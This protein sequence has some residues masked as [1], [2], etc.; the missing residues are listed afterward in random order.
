MQ[1]WQQDGQ[2]RGAGA[3]RLLVHGFTTEY[4]IDPETGAT[5]EVDFVE[6]SPAGQEAFIRLRKPMRDVLEIEPLDPNAPLTILAHQRKAVIEEAY[7][8]WKRGGEVPVTGTPLGAWP[9][10][11]AKQAEIIRHAGIASVEDLAGATE[12]Q[13]SR[14]RLPNNYDLR[15]M[16]RRFLAAKPQ[17]QEAG[18]LAKL[19]AEN[20]RLRSDLDELK[21][22]MRQLVAKQPAVSAADD[23]DEELA[24]LREMAQSAGIKRV[25]NKSKA[26]LLAELEAF[27]AA[28]ANG[29]DELVAA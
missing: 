13:I 3:V 16:A 27:E 24:I 17:A 6:Y 21:A 1:P 18:V 10:I 11:T 9:A 29:H 22:M 28:K 8:G 2:M 19:E 7:R 12:S 4:K 23:D 26:T 20:E 14:V 15:D 25:G 5:R